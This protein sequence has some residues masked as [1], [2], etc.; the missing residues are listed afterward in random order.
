ME[1]KIEIYK[2]MFIMVVIIAMASAVTAVLASPFLIFE[3]TATYYTY[4]NIIIVSTV[5]STVFGK[6]TINSNK[7]FK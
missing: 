2:L 3:T 1:V 7:G 5:V 6:V 4:Q